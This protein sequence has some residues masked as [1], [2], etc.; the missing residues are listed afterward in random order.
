M[1]DE[2]AVDAHVDAPHIADIPADPVIAPFPDPVPVQFNHAPLTTQVDPRYAHTRSEWIVD[3]NGYLS[4][5][6]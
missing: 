5:F 4:S 1:E 2:H 6:L 3:D